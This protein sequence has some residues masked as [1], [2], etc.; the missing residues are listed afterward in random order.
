MKEETKTKQLTPFESARSDILKMESQFSMAL[1][2]HIKA[3]KFI[4]TALTALQTNPALLTADRRSFFSALLRCAADGLLPNGHEAAMVPFNSKGGGTTV[5]YLPMVAGILKKIRNSG[6]L[7]SLATQIVKKN[8][9]FKYW[10]NAD[11]EHLEHEPLMFGDRGPILGAYMVAKTKDGAIYAEVM[12][13]EEIER[14]RGVSRAKNSGPW[15]D[16]WDEMAKKTVIKRGAKRLPMS[17]DLMETIKADDEL[18]DLNSRD[19][20]GKNIADRFMQSFQGSGDNGQRDVTDANS[21]RVLPDREE[22]VSIDAGDGHLQAQDDSGQLQDVAGEHGGGGTEFR[23]TPDPDWS[24]DQTDVSAKEP[25]RKKGR[26]END[27]GPGVAG[28]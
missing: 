5:A 20:Q 23:D 16:W 8:D 14:V 19:N 26:Y 25:K 2:P 11:G 6:E 22:T 21:R 3:D 4:R 15:V 17:S 18:Y 27:P 7:S 9:K 24:S 13:T 28:H 10:V 12:T 1:P